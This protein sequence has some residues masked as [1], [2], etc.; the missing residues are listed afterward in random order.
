MIGSPNDLMRCDSGLLARC[1]ADGKLRRCYQQPFA[2]SKCSVTTYL[3][4]GGPVTTLCQGV[5]CTCTDNKTF[6]SYP[7]NGIVTSIGACIWRYNPGRAESWNG[8]IMYY[9][10]INCSAPNK[11]WQISYQGE[12]V[13]GNPWVNEYFKRYGNSPVGVY[14][15]EYNSCILPQTLTVS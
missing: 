13:F 2:C 12:D 6:T 14:T 3:V 11:W 5:G 9:C 7:W 4:T 10:Q 15:A 1:K 8:Y